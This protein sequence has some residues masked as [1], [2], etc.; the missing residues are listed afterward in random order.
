[1]VVE[2]DPE[3]EYCPECGSAYCNGECMSSN[4]CEYCGS[5]NCSGECQDEEYNDEPDTYECPRCGDPYCDGSCQSTPCTCGNCEECGYTETQ[6][7]D[8]EYTEL[9]QTTINKIQQDL[10]SNNVQIKQVKINDTTG[11]ALLY[12]AGAGLNTNGIITSATNFIANAG[13]LVTNIGIAVSGAGLVVGATQTWIGYSDGDIT[14]ADKLNAISTAL[15]AVG[16]V[17]AFIP[18]GQIV[19]GVLGVSSCIV[20]LVSTF[21]S[22][23][24]QKEIFIKFDDGTSFYMCLLS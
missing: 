17:C 8:E 22:D 24:M 7:T 14:T 6:M 5:Q 11:E 15:N 13:P 18:G 23:N 19:S 16:I 12:A 3:P 20:G 21:M 10:Q 9:G 2:P 1:M 4:P